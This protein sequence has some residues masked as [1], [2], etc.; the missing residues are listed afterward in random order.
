VGA[1][2]EIRRLEKKDRLGM[3]DTEYIEPIVKMRPKDAFY[4]EKEEMKLEEATGR[5]SCEYVMSYPPG[6]PI[7]APGELI[8][9]EIIEHIN[10]AK[11]KGCYLMGTEDSK[12][13]YI[14]VVKNRRA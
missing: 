10:Y 2:V 6:I 13:N 14:N 4:A 7:L 5:I 11:E 9:N 3:L 12:I 8:T 1:L